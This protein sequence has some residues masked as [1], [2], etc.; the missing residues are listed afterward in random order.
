MGARLENKKILVLG[1]LGFIGSNLALRCQEEG[2]HVTVYDSL[3]DHGGGL[4]RAAGDNFRAKI[5]SRGNTVDYAELYR[6]YAG[7]DPK[8]D[9]MVEARG[10]QPGDGK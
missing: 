9:A 8:I 2:A 10:L 4:T 5:L 3:M 6:A 7:R 1:G